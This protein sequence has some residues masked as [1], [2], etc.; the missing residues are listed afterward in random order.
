[1]DR[2]EDAVQALKIGAYDYITKPFDE[3]DLLIDYQKVYRRPPI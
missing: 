3:S 1:M 2:A